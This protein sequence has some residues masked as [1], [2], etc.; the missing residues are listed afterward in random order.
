MLLIRQE[1]YGQGRLTIKE[2][3]KDS[4][5]WKQ[6]WNIILVWEEP[7]KYLCIKISVFVRLCSVGLEGSLHITKSE[8][9]SQF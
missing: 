8:I 6:I 2:D 4:W 1:Y 9:C 5:R 7:E 3:P